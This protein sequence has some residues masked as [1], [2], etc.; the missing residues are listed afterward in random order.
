M[1]LSVQPE[2]R[3]ERAIRLGFPLS[4]RSLLKSRVGKVIDGDPSFIDQT[5]LTSQ[6]TQVVKD[7]TFLT[8]NGRDAD[9]R[10]KREVS[11]KRRD[12]ALNNQR[13][14]MLLQTV[15]DYLVTL[16]NKFSATNGEKS[17]P[18]DILKCLEC[19]RMNIANENDKDYTSRL[20][21]RYDYAEQNHS[22][23][24]STTIKLLDDKEAENGSKRLEVNQIK[25]ANIQLL[26][27]DSVIDDSLSIQNVTNQSLKDISISE[28]STVSI[29][30]TNS[31]ESQRIYIN[32]T[33]LRVSKSQNNEG[34]PAVS[35][36]GQQQS[37]ITVNEDVT[38]V[39]PLLIM[40]S[41]STRMHYGTVTKDDGKFKKT[42]IAADS[43]GT[44]ETRIQ[45][46]IDLTKQITENVTSMPVGYD[47]TGINSNTV[48]PSTYPSF[49]GLPENRSITTTNGMQSERIHIGKRVYSE[50]INRLLLTYINIYAMNVLF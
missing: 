40:E 29:N 32:D 4:K 39:K 26:E 36:N 47:V 5:E 41:S 45:T 3:V 2:T 27:P 18:R 24:F 49:E 13:C 7:D 17:L 22:N 38:S 30:Y 9:T 6:I 34:T 12:C 19:K 46:I 21:D 42:T 16:N 15:Q 11:R 20:K 1:I 33:G 14:K 28:T 10:F 48:H 44:T 25:A 43:I 35:K 50:I 37:I 23:D 8:I 31:N